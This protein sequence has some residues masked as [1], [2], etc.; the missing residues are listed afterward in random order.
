M[1]YLLQQINQ[2]SNIVQT[3]KYLLGQ[4]VFCL[5]VCLLACLDGWLVSVL[6][7]RSCCI[8]YSDLKFVILPSQSLEYW[9]YKHVIP[10]Q[11]SIHFFSVVGFELKAFNLSHFTSHFL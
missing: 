6:R 1:I 5:F 10:P 3:I 11:A 2:Y 8:A 7:A 9:N 4:F